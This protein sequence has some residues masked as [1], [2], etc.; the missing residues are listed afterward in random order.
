MGWLTLPRKPEPEMASDAE[1]VNAYASAAAL[2]FR[3]AIDNTPVDQ[4][5]SLGRT[6]AWL[7]DLVTGP[8]GIPLKIARCPPNTQGMSMGWSVGIG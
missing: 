3:D 6:S 8:G 5:L 7:L 1:E 4:V 2:A